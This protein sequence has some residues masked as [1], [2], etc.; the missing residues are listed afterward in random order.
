MDE[1]TSLLVEATSWLIDGGM[2]GQ[3]LAI[4]HSIT[5]IQQK[6]EESGAPWSTKKSFKKSVQ[7]FYVTEW[8]RRLT[9][10]LDDG[11]FGERMR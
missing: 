6:M 11:G 8:I 3:S 1:L 10:E 7:H 9:I 5:S 4:D 2:R